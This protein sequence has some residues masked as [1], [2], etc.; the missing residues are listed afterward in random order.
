MG[1]ASRAVPSDVQRFYQ[2]DHTKAYATLQDLLPLGEHLQLMSGCAIA[3]HWI[4]LY[5]QS[6]LLRES[7]GAN[8]ATMKLLKGIAPHLIGEL[9]AG[10]VYD[11]RDI[12]LAPTSGSYHEFSLR[13]SP[14]LC[15]LDDIAY[16]GLNAT[17]RVYR[18]LYGEKLVAAGRVVADLLF[19]QPPFYALSGFGGLTPNSGI[20]GGYAIR[21]IPL[22]RYYGKAKLFEN[23]ELR[24]K[25]IDFS[26]FRQAFNLG[27]VEFLDAGRT[28]ADY[29]GASELDG[30]GLG[31]KYGAGA[32][33]RV[34][35]GETF[36]LRIDV[37]WSPDADPVGFYI[38]VDHVF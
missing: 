4:T 38:D 5:D 20:G 10:G 14:W 27:A 34:Q 26:V 7:R 29:R 16:C 18:S 19:G 33:L 25:L 8:T 6:L 15:T 37:A 13:G 35:W 23:M 24:S 30:P 32:G 28:W 21:G 12:E 2:Y 3:K 36:L 9:D 11:T 31:L 1:N 17:A 22:E